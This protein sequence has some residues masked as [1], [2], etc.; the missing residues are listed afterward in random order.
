MSA[1]HA[2]AAAPA[3]PRRAPQSTPAQ[4]PARLRL[5]RAPAEARTRTPFVL[6]CMAVL[7]A[8]LLAA[9]VLNTQMASG[10][11][12][13]YDLSNELGRLDQDAKDLS[14]ELDRKGSPSELANSAAALGMVPAAQVGWVRLAEKQVQVA[15]A[16]KG[17]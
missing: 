10:A 3:R 17:R 4:T 13:K 1:A 12:A 11:Y 15:P 16:A 14:A 8:A 9:L 7:G 2:Y 6:V 5:V